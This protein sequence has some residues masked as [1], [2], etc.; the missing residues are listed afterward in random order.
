MKH[1]AKR[2]LPF[3]IIIFFG[4]LFHSKYINEFPSYTHAWAQADRYAL[5]LGFVN[6]NLNFFKPQTFVMNHKFP[7]DWKIPST[8]SI[9]AVDFPIHDYIP[10]V[11]MKISG[12]NSVYIFRLYILLYSFIGLFFLFKLAY[13]QTN[14][15]WKS[16]FILIF[17]ATSP[18]FVFYQGGFLPTIPSL[19]NAIIG[20]YFYVKHLRQAEKHNFR[21]TIVFLT[22]STLSR[23]TFGVI[24]L[25][26][27]CLEILKMIRGESQLKNKITPV[28]LSVLLIISYL[29]YNS[30]LRKAYGSIFLNDF[31][32]AASFKEAKEIVKGIYNSWLAQYL[33]TFHYVLSF[34]L[35]I[36]ALFF[37]F[38]RRTGSVDLPGG[39]WL[40]ILALFI[41]YCAFA[42]LMLQ[43]FSNHDYYFLDTFFLPI[44]LSLIAII[45]YIPKLNVKHYYVYSGI[46]ITLLSIPLVINAI[47]SQR[48]RRNTGYWDRTTATTN[49]FGGSETFLD[50]LKVNRDAR[51]LVIDAYAPNIPFILMNRKGYAIMSTTK[52]NI[53]D[54]LNWDYDYII[55]QNDFFVSDIYVA[56]P[57][58]VSRI[59]KIADN[60][61]ISVCILLEKADSDPSLVKFLALEEISPVFQRKMTFDS[62]S[63]P[64]WTNTQST[65]KMYHS[66]PGAGYVTKDM[67]YGLTYK[68]INLKALTE[69]NSIL[70]FSA[71]FQKDTLNDCEIV[72]FI[73]SNGQNV[74]YKSYNLKEIL[75]TKNVWE[76][77]DLIFNIPRIESENNEF[78]IYIWN[79]EKSNLYVDDFE[80]KLY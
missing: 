7:D 4:G 79:R 30:Y 47:N 54:A 13:L 50:S 15:T 11:F 53:Q 52:A 26:I 71:Y 69:K 73:N 10:A 12:T 66:A 18:V 63:D 27:F 45:S 57:E 49:N 40:L 76:R 74:Y 34:S 36:P 77:A 37:A 41:G 48:I 43:Q 70:L 61:K 1:I 9:T 29:A 24:L 20:I 38:R 64:L 2:V 25:A 78:G 44:I 21:L 67:P 19:S 75:K 39:F 46:T 80:F 14:D 35:V 65:T 62:I 42:V 58:I 55:V 16:V 23:T 17:A 59:K 5:S 22:L 33:S 32:P 72:A 56:Y 28:V 60:G 3:F 31:R 51:I 6:N 68:T 8:N